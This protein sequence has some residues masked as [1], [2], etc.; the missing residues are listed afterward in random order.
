IG[1]LAALGFFGI[2]GG[3][4]PWAE[5]FDRWQSQARG[6]AQASPRPVA[7]AWSH[8]RYPF[9][10]GLVKAALDAGGGAAVEDLFTAPPTGTRQVM[11]GFGAAAPDGGVWAEDLGADAVPILDASFAY[12]AAERMGAWLFQ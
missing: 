2:R 8:F 3:D 1:D 10:A 9:G 4:V 11:A 6:Q 5:V 12:V 7:L